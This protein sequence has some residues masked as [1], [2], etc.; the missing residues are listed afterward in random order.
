[1]ART[2]PC[3]V[4]ISPSGKGAKAP[5]A[6]RWSLTIASVERMDHLAGHMLYLQ[7][8]LVIQGEV[9]EGRD[10]PRRSDHPGFLLL[11]AGVDL[12]AQHTRGRVVGKDPGMKPL[13]AVDPRGD[14]QR[15]EQQCPDP[16]IL[17]RVRHG[18]R[19]LRRAWV[20]FVTDEAGVG[21]DRPLDAVGYYPD[22]MVNVI[23]LE[24]VGQ[25]P[26]ARCTPLVPPVQSLPRE[27][28][29]ALEPLGI[30]GQDGAQ[31]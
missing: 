7:A 2:G 28:T 5:N 19:N 14:R 6:G 12:I 22:E 23:D 30:T 9:V 11:P 29:I 17:T 8:R 25:P 20:V 10:V 18:Q 31:R 4:D 15:A 26:L 21:D 1:M 27:C 16:A 3:C 24:Q 13:D